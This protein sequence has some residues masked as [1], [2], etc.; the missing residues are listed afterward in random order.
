[1]PLRPFNL[2]LGI[3]TD[4]VHINRIRANLTR[5]QHDP[6]QLDRFLRRFLTPREHNDFNARFIGAN[7]LNQELFTVSKYLAGRCVS[8]E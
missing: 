3:G 7:G 6:K 4:I 8:Y 2:L 5:S 1:M